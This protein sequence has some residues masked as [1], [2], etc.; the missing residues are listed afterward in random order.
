MMDLNSPKG[1]PNLWKCIAISVA[2]TVGAS[3]LLA[4]N[5]RDFGEYLPQNSAAQRQGCTSNM[6]KGTAQRQHQ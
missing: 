6:D 3:G 1:T 2:S 4:Q 5:I